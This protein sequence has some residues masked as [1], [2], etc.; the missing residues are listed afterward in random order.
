MPTTT[1]VINAGEV[2][3]LHSYVEENSM[4]SQ[5]Q[6]Q[7]IV[8]DSSSLNSTR[9]TQET[10]TGQ[11]LSSS[12][13]RGLPTPIRPSKLKKI[14]AGYDQN[15]VDFLVD[16]FTR[17]FSVGYVGNK[18]CHAKNNAKI[19]QQHPE[20]VQK[21]IDRELEL[22]RFQGPFQ[23]L[24]FESYHVSP[25]SLREKNVP[26][27]FR[28]IHDLSFPYDQSTSVNA[29][30][31]EES[32]TVTYATVQD[33][34]G[35]I[36][37]LGRR[38]YLAKADIKSA[39]RLIPIRPDQ[40]HL[41]CFQFQGA[42]YYDR[43]LQMG[44]ASSC[45][46][47]ERFSRAI[48]WAL[49]EKCG[50]KN[51]VHYLDDFLFLHKTKKLCLS[52]LLQFQNLADFIGLPLAPEKTDGPAQEI[53]FLG[54]QLSTITMEA[55]LPQE[56]VQAYADE[57]RLFLN[58]NACTLKQMQAI[59]GRLQWA[60]TV[61]LPG[62]PFLRRMIDGTKG[63]KSAQQVVQITREMKLDLEVW[64]HFLD[65][66]NGHSFFLMKQQVSSTD[67]QMYTDA[68]KIACGGFLKSRWFQVIFPPDWA[69]KDIAFLELY[70]VVV[71]L[72]VFG[73]SLSNHRVCFNTDNMS[74]VYIINLQ[75]SKS[76]L[77][78]RLVRQLVLTALTFNVK[79]SAKHLPGVTNV[80]ADLIS[81]LQVK[82]RD[83]YQRGM[84]MTPE[85]VPL[86]ML[87][88]NWIGS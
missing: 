54:I 21:F 61:V 45:Q 76:P 6:L 71:A 38:S 37:D 15:E 1:S 67:L 23:K 72:Q 33:A 42:Y 8:E 58:K 12:G 25:L 34:V 53:V 40:Y 44:C 48:E 5:P 16:G 85:V 73:G 28:L 7:H 22:G 17:G 10:L 74:I 36:L 14:L 39:F 81:R 47:F 75:T 69:E 49:R 29:G 13:S 62:R 46:L 86:E 30:I 24:P 68:S 63:K 9:R 79:F 52:Y 56:K 4:L 31:P 80:M 70:A 20:E 43:S 26:G 83:L 18:Q 51:M 64:L 57:I 27:T 82:Q 35:Q 32:A 65:N 87:P 3:M 2:I 84:K 55:V 11:D 41:F 78:M 77:I 59:L 50:V 88:E 19:A 66:F 60:N